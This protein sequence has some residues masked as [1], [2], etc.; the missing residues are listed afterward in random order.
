MT[1]AR[2]IPFISSL[3]RALLPGLLGLLCVLAWPET[4]L[5]AWPADADWIAVNQGGSSQADGTLDENTDYRNVVGDASYPATYWYNDGVHL[6]FR[7]RLDGSPQGG[8]GQNLLKPFGWGVL[9]D[10]DG[11]WSDYEF[12]VIANGIDE[13]VTFY[14]NTSQNTAYD[15]SDPPE[16]T[17]AVYDT[18]TNARVSLADSSFNGTP[19]YYVDFQVSWATFMAASGLNEASAL[20]FVFGTSNNGTTLGSDISGSTNLDMGQG[21]GDP[22]YPSVADMSLTKSHAANFAVEDTG[23]YTLTV[24]NA[25]PS[26]IAGPITVTDSLPAGLTFVSATG[27]NWNCAAAGQDVT[28]THPGLLL[29][30]ASLPPI[31][32]T[33]T[34]DAA[35]WPSV[36]NTASASANTTDEDLTNNTASDFTTVERRSDLAI[37]KTDGQATAIP[38]S[39]IAYTITLTNLGPTSVTAATVS[40]TLPA[41]LLGPLFA[42]SAGAY[43]AGSGQ[44]TG[45]AL[46]AG[47]SATLTLTATLDPAATGTLTNTVSVTPPPTWIDPAAGNDSASDTDTLTPQADL[48]IAK[49]QDGSFTVGESGTFTIQ[50]ENLG[51]SDSNGTITVTD[52]L[53]SELAYVGAAGAGWTCSVSGATVT[54]TRAGTVPPAT[55][56]PAITLTV[57][58]AEAAAGAWVT[59]TASLG[60]ATPDPDGA[61]DTSTIP[62][63]V[64]RRIS[65]TVYADADHSG[66]RDGGEAG[67][68]VP[69]YAKL[70]SGAV[71]TQSVLVDPVTGAYVLRGVLDGSYTVFLDDNGSLADASPTPPAGWIAVSPASLSQFAVMAGA[72]VS[73][74]DFGLFSGSRVDG[75]V[76]FD[77]GAGGGV[78]HDGVQNGAEAARAGVSIELTDAGGTTVL[79]ATATDGAGAFGFWLPASLAGQ[80]VRIRASD[81]F[82]FRSASGSPGTTGGSYDPGTDEL[83][84]V[85]AAGNAYTGVTFGDVPESEFS[86]SR[87]GTVLA[88]GTIVYAASFTA[89]T[90]G[91]LAF[92]VASAWPATVYLDADAS[93][94]LTAGDTA[95]GGSLAVVGGNVYRLLLEVS[96]P[97]ATAAGSVDVATWT[98]ALTYAGT[99]VVESHAVLDTTAVAPSLDL[100]KE[101]SINGGAFTSSPLGA[102]P[103]DLVTYR[104]TYTN[105]SA[106]TFQNLVVSD[107]IPPATTFVSASGA[108][109]L[110]AGVLNWSLGALGP[111]AS[112]TVEFTVQIQ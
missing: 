102:V 14:Q 5:A 95:L 4:A 1:D 68:G 110:S 39:A 35:A 41:A 64:G 56:L 2:R 83:T 78:A 85:V 108:P 8:G 81:G 37:A 33:V 23:V 104:V 97:A 72:N 53:A 96:V 79:Q 90:A 99:A 101:M 84:F 27:S 69:V 43:D 3:A 92:A 109:T 7:M 107:P 65:G 105:P 55:M 67:P 49:T 15:A 106:L 44:W 91:D 76:F 70:V 63:L 26:N 9:I 59:N 42:P 50:V 112:G 88:G 11:D 46:A 25:G 36:T 73:G 29:S 54:C 38:G 10:T 17:L 75:L 94:T 74:V 58:P 21:G 60:G 100:V 18:A 66:T 87:A 40:D 93:G 57:L 80:T 13:S 89:G 61:N 98:A 47:Q 51:P 31:T 52:T 34:V 20:S 62:V 32:L 12:S 28:C 24:S 103:G 111:G 30:G 71:V 86:P 6:S 22:V 48:A 77:D 45:L 16:V 19:D 82:G